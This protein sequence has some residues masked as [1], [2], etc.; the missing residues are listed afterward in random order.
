MTDKMIPR[1]VQGAVIQNSFKII[2]DILTKSLTNGTWVAVTVPALK[3][4]KKAMAKMRDNSAFKIS[5]N[6]TGKPYMTILAN[7]LFEF[8][9]NADASTTLFYAQSSAASGSLEVLLAD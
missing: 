4:C 8:P 9:M 2:Y 7:T 1:D 3:G 6:S 5:L